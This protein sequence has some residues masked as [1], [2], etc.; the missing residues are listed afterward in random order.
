LIEAA[1]NLLVSGFHVARDIAGLFE[2]LDNRGR[3]E[4]DR[5]CGCERL[6]RGDVGDADE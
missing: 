5:R 4:S 1:Y 3:K 2:I 6:L